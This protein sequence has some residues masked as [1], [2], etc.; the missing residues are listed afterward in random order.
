MGG[1]PFGLAL[2]VTAMVLTQALGIVLE[3]LLVRY[4]WLGRQ[5]AAEPLDRYA[6]YGQLYATLVR[7][8]DQDD[9]HGHLR[10]TV[11]QLF[12]TINTLVSYSLALMVCV[13]AYLLL[14]SGA[15]RLGPALA[16]AAVMLSCLGVSYVVAVIRFRE[17]ARSVAIARA[18]L[19]GRASPVG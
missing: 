10:R 8:N 7:L 17:M 13:V 14:P 16:Y 9:T 15:D 5:A 4:R 3:E 11:A 18:A 19:D 1:L 6:E 12:L 2:A